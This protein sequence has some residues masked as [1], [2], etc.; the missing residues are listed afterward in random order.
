[1]SRHGAFRHK[2]QFEADPQ[3]EDRAYAAKGH[4]GVAWRVLGWE[5]EPGPSE[6][7]D[8]E[9]REWVTD[10]EPAPVQTG[11]VVAVMV[12]DNQRFVFDLDDL[13]PIDDDA[14]CDECGQI[15]CG[16]GRR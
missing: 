14:Y 4:R 9:T 8:K 7:F 15:G 1:M 5:V 13:K 10:E 3:F 12:G 16:H 2:V 11:K 6:W